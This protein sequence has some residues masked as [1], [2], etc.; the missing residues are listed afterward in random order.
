LQHAGAVVLPVLGTALVAAVLAGFAQ[1][2][3]VFSVEP[4]QF[5]PERMNP[6]EGLKQLFSTRQ[7]FELLKLI[8][9]T[10]A[11][12]FALFAVVSGGFSAAV[13]SVYAQPAGAGLVGWTLVL[14]LFCVA[15]L[16]YA[17]VSAADFGLQWFEYLKGQRM[18][19]EDVRRERRDLDGDPHVRAQRRQLLRELASGQGGAPL[20]KAS[21]LLT[22]PTHV[23]VALWYE[24]GRTELPVVIAKGLEGEALALRRAAHTLHVPIV[25]NRS[26]A[27][28]LHAEVGLNEPIDEA[29]FQA[30]AEVLRWVRSLGGQRSD[31]ESMNT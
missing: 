8:A 26:L 28:R 16:V 25:E 19:K 13:R 1:V 7:L 12:G 9:K 11:L 20:A 10:T 30:V 18:T 4:L 6:A 15:A 14:W 29:H 22:N 24:R 27:R 23:A 5:K 21:V 17:V 3:G 31:G 2:R